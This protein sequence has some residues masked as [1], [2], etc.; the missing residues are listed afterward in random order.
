MSEKEEEKKEPSEEENKKELEITV[1]VI[2]VSNI[3]GGLRWQ[4]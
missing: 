1:R 2:K 3:K 4:K